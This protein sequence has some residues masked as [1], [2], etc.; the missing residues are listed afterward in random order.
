MITIDLVGD[1]AIVADF[2]DFP[3]R[4]TKAMVRAMNRGINSG[5]T[6]MVSRVSRDVGMK[7][8]DVRSAMPVREASVGHPTA[9]LSTTLKRVALIKFG[10]K[11]PQPSRGRGRGVTYKIGEQGRGRVEG[12]FMA[13]MKSGHT[14]VF[15]RKGWAPRG[16]SGP[17]ASSKRSTGA[18]SNNLPIRQLYGPSLGQVFAKYRREGLARTYEMFERNFDH[19][20]QFRATGALD[21]AGDGA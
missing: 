12:A 10:A 19:E 7:S 16:T 13:T 17:T 3:G 18:W 5:R 14:G 4:V 21:G 15:I 2:R 9:Q 6:L 8:A 20:L 1:K 11:G